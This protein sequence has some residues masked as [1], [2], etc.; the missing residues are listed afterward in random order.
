M[1]KTRLVKPLAALTLMLAS[2][3]FLASCAT[4]PPPCNGPQS[5]NLDT[6]IDTVKSTLQS[7]CEAHFDRYYD[8][9]LGI[10]EGDPKPENKRI[11]SEFL[12]WSSDQGLLSKRQ[13]KNY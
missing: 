5:K 4:T 1:N 2:L 12:V 10:A 3:F 13:A 6:A 8:D 9:L 11:F 7:G